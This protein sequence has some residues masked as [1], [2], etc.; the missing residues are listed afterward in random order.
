MQ[1]SLVKPGHFINARSRRTF[2]IHGHILQK[3]MED[4]GFIFSGTR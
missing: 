4:I 1:K 3:M 2:Q